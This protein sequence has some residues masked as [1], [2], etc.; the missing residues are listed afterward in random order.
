MTKVLEKTGPLLAGSKRKAATD[1]F[2]NEKTIEKLQERIE[3]LET[4]KT[5]GIQACDLLKERIEELGTILKEFADAPQCMH[6]PNWVVIKCEK[7]LKG[8]N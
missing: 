5:I 8:G 7:A 2:S 1:I 6:V 4:A 3:E